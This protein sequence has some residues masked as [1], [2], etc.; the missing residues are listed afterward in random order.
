MGSSGVAKNATGAK[1]AHDTLLVFDAQLFFNI[2]IQK[3]TNGCNQ[4]ASDTYRCKSDAAGR[5]VADS[6]W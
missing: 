2:E 4:W 3:L 5:I 1:A 6:F